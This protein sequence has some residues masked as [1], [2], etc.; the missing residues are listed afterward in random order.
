MTDGEP[1]PAAISLFGGFGLLLASAFFA[2]GGATGM[3]NFAG[4]MGTILIMLPFLVPIGGGLLLLFLL[5]LTAGGGD[6]DGQANAQPNQRRQ[7][8]VGRDRVRAGPGDLDLDAEAI[9]E[10]RRQ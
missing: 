10:Y 2:I 6:D 4:F 8:P 7:G 1:H 5:L 9:N 3:A